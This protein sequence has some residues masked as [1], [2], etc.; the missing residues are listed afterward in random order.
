[1]TQLVIRFQT[2]CHHLFGIILSYKCSFGGAGRPYC[3]MIRVLII[4]QM[5]REMKGV[6]E[7]VSRNCRWMGQQGLRKKKKEKRREGKAL[8]LEKE[9]GTQRE[10]D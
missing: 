10:Q 6:G 1:M 5:N 7:A 3:L 2:D 8:Q 4:N 9:T